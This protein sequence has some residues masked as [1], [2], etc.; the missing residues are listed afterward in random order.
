VITSRGESSIGRSARIAATAKAA[1]GAELSASRGIVN[2][3]KI[4]KH[5][6]HDFENHL[7]EHN[8]THAQ[9]QACKLQDELGFF[10]LKWDLVAHC[11]EMITGIR[12]ACAQCFDQ[13]LE[14]FAGHNYVDLPYSCAGD[15]SMFMATKHPH[16]EKASHIPVDKWCTKCMTEKVAVTGEC[17]AGANWQDVILKL[18]TEADLTRD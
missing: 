2:P 12:P 16:W 11:I 7:V 6:A 1:S 3:D 14:S 8:F 15:C 4:F 17:L 10:S 5:L 18:G 13:M 9:K